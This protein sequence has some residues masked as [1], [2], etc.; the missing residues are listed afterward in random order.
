MAASFHSDFPPFT[1]PIVLGI[2]AEVVSIL[3]ELAKR[4]LSWRQV[5]CVFNRLFM[6]LITL[7]YRR[8][9]GTPTQ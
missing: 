7:S 2:F 9:G 4:K 3:G 1:L 5:W 6:R 8:V